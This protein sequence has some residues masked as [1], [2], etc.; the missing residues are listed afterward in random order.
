MRILCVS[1]SYTV[2]GLIVQAKSVIQFEDWQ[3][4][5][6]MNMT[7]WEA[8]KIIVSSSP[9]TSL[10]TSSTCCAWPKPQWCSYSVLPV[11][12]FR[13]A[14]ESRRAIHCVGD[15][16]KCCLSINPNNKKKKKSF[17]DFHNIDGIRFYAVL[18]CY[19]SNAIQSLGQVTNSCNTPIPG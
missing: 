18:L 16:K 17:P 12:Y 14:G 2:W 9:I 19:I 6:E 10:L 13:R 8:I 15:F 7:N 5:D 3:F 4:I 11:W 1:L